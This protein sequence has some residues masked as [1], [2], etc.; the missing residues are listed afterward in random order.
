MKR[1]RLWTSLAKGTALAGMVT[2]FGIAAASAAPVIV[3]FDPAGAGLSS[4]GAFQAD[5]YTLTDFATATIDN[6]T[7]AFTET[8]TLR[9]DVFNLGST[10]IQ[11]PTSGL[12]N[13]TGSAAYGLY[14][15]FTASGVLPGWNAAAPTTPINGTFTSVNYSFVGDPGNLD[16]VSNGGVL[17]DVGGNNIALG[18][19]VL[20]GGPNNIVG[21]TNLG[22]PFASVLL[23]L[24]QDAAGHMFMTSPPNVGFQEDV[25]FNTPGVFS[26]NNTGATTIL[27]ITGGGGN[28]DFLA[29][30][31]PEPASLALV[32]SGLLG[33]GL[34]RRRR[35]KG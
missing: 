5:R 16:T 10:K 21:V 26:F 9:I 6:A 34:I 30:A 32:G 24:A 17:T 4:Q 22:T 25:F 35:R 29:G 18:S 19:G 13:G 2:V 20:A 1:T 31:V 3:T 33:L 28:G 27:T 15:T 14:K 12:G 7:G 23:T 8:G 11:G